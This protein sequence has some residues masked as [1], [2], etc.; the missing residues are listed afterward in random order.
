MF[1]VQ[2]CSKVKLT[3]LI[4][5]CLQAGFIYIILEN[6]GFEFQESFLKTL[7]VL[8]ICWDEL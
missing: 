8:E 2:Y 6:T 5:F 3:P 1:G 4:L 7:K